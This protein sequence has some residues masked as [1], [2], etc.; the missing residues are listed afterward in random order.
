MGKMTDWLRKCCGSFFSNS[1]VHFLDAICRRTGQLPPKIKSTIGCL[2]GS[3][4][5]DEEK[6]YVCLTDLLGEAAFVLGNGGLRASDILA[7]SYCIEEDGRRDRGVS[8][9]GIMVECS[10]PT[11]R[12]ELLK[13]L[14]HLQGVFESV[15]NRMAV[16]PSGF[17]EFRWLLARLVL[18]W[19]VLQL[20]ACCGLIV[21]EEGDACLP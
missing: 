1:E 21:L 5:L 3:R 15:A 13:H 11:T 2:S 14:T 16:T 4:A 12:E 20:V 9:E 18:A 6:A 10:M 7:W 8:A 17:Q 19:M